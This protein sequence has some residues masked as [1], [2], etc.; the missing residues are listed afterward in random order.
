VQLPDYR[1]L[2]L[3][4]RRFL[5]RHRHLQNLRQ[6]R[7]S[8]R[9]QGRHLQDLRQAGRAVCLQEALTHKADSEPDRADEARQS[10]PGV[11]P[12]LRKA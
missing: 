6:A 4:H 10:L 8:V 5:L 12:P 11:A 2:L 7:G 9:L 1:L 3:R